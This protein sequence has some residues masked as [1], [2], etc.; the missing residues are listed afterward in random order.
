MTGLFVSRKT[1]KP[2][3]FNLH[4]IHSNEKLFNIARNPLEN[5][6]LNEN[7]SILHRIA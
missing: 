7:I 5:L 3:R 1:R 6:T 2:D 4:L